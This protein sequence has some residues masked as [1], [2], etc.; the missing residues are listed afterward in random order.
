MVVSVE[1]N[2]SFKWYSSGCETRVVTVAGDI[3]SYISS[4]SA[5]ATVI[6]MP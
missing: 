3:S 5:A 2:D 4:G 6:T 1:S